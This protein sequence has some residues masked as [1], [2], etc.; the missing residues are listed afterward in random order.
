M[1]KIKRKYWT[2]GALGTLL[3]GFG[4]CALL[5]SAFLKHNPEIPTW[6]WIV[7]GTLSLIII[8]AGINFLFASFENKLKLNRND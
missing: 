3:L 5:E 8:M 7:A 2:F 6:Q 1:N 4:L